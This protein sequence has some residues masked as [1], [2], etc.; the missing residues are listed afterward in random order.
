MTY[1]VSWRVV[2]PGERTL[3]LDAF[4]HAF[5]RRE[6]AVGFVLEKLSAFPAH[7]YDRARGFWGRGASDRPCETRFAIAEDIAVSVEG[8]RA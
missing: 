4:P 1:H 2:G 3:D 7:G 6:D 5:V 8:P